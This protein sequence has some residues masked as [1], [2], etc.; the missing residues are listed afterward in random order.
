MESTGAP[1]QKFS[2]WVGVCFTLNYVVGSGFLTLP[3]AFQRTGTLLGVAVLG[4]FGYFSI[5]ATVFV[6]EATA[7][8]TAVMERAADV[9][10]P[11]LTLKHKAGYSSID[12][13]AHAKDDA[14]LITENS[15]HSTDEP[16]KILLHS[17]T[18]RR[19]EITELCELFLGSNGRRVFTLLICI[20]MYGTLWAYC[21]VFAKSFAVQFAL[22]DETQPEEGSTYLIY[23]F[24]FGCIVVPLSLMELSEQIFIQVSLSIFRIV[25][26]SLM[27]IT[28]AVSFSACDQEFGE[29]S[30]NTCRPVSDGGEPISILSIHPSNLYLFLPMAAYAYIFHHSVPALSAPIEDKRSLSR[31]FA[32]ALL[33]SFVA[34]SLLGAV[35]SAYFGAATQSSSNL[36]WKDYRGVLNADGSVPWYASFVSNFVVLFPAIDVA[37]AYP[38]NAFTLGNNLM[39]AYYGADMKHHEQS[40]LKTSI[41]RLIA[42]LPPFLGAAMVNDLHHITAYTGL[43][44]FAIAFVVPALLAYYSTKKMAELGMSDNTVHSSGWTDKN[45]QYVMIGVGT[46]LIVGVFGCQLIYGTD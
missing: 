21:S 29:L 44:G 2:F 8:A 13:S 30:S 42:A 23:L 33:V 46:A 22:A 45:A 4:L 31:M 24:V 32:V 41:F 3:W 17:G 6:L 9:E 10:L 35:V 39:S 25:L 40:R 15:T 26:L 11:K 27:I 20:Y 7:R 14:R 38:L 37:S 5:I 34:Y 19:I 43:T 12:S 18:T 36:D 1:L 16:P 28:T